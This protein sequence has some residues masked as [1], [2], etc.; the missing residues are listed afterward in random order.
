MQILGDVINQVCNIVKV[1]LEWNLIKANICY[2][3]N[4]V[5]GKYK[6]PNLIFFLFPTKVTV[7][8]EYI[9]NPEWWCMVMV[10]CRFWYRRPKN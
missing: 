7:F 1:L 8:K 10:C 4:S 2:L 5:A 6:Y 3:N 9:A